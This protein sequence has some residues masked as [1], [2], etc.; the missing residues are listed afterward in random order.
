MCAVLGIK[1]G[2]QAINKSFLL[3]ER[4]TISSG[5]S[6]IEKLELKFPKK[7]KEKN[8]AFFLWEGCVASEALRADED[9]DMIVVRVR[10]PRYKPA[11]L[12]IGYPEAGTSFVM[13]ISAAS[14]GELMTQNHALKET[15]G[16]DSEGAES[17]GG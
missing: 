10:R 16:T 11:K 8:E 13:N 14:N 9:D 12:R 15:E 1:R 4:L 7:P 17:G 3:F 5:D 6:E 2:P